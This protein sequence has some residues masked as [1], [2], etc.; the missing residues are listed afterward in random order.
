M[1][2][3]PNPVNEVSARVVAGCVAV[4]S[5]ATILSGQTWF[6]AVIAAGFIARV[7]T[8]PTLSP[9]GQLATRVI[10]PRLGLPEKL[11]AGP[12]KRFAQG[13]GAVISSTAAVL[14]LGFGLDMEADVVLSLIVVAATLESAFAVCIGCMVFSRLMRAGIIPPEV[15]E[16]CNDIWTRV[17]QP[18]AGPR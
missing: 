16:S 11:V 10:T 5:L 2:T 13:M 3:F 6:A 9:L 18:A 1:L 7:L 8:G 17:P 15:C 4:L 12:P 14:T